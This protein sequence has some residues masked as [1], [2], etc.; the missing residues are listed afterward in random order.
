MTDKEEITER[1]DRDPPPA[2]LPGEPQR[3]IPRIEMPDESQDW[4]RRGREPRF[5]QR[6]MERF[7]RE[8]TSEEVEEA[9]HPPLEKFLEKPRDKGKKGRPVIDL[10]DDENHNWLQEVRRQRLEREQREGT[11]DSA[12]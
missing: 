11:A 12:V 10:T 3:V 2:R 7:G 4:L 6:F 1:D 8:P 5:R 9:I